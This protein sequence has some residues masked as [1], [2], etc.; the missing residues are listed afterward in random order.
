VRIL[1]ADDHPASRQLLCG[2]LATEFDVVGDVGDGEALV[3][4]ERLLSPDVI[5]TDISMP[6]LNG[7]AAAAKILE[8]RPSARIIFV[9]VNADVELVE[10]GLADGALGYVLKRSAGDDLVPAVHA[11]LN[12]RV[13]VSDALSACHVRAGR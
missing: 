12:G 8:R 13:F 1:V 6:F 10:R 11:A 5:L 4:A 3:S 9:S 7:I 2:L